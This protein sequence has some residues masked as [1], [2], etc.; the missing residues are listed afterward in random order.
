MY[1]D[2]IYLFKIKLGFYINNFLFVVLVNYTITLLHRNNY[3]TNN[4]DLNFHKN[5]CV[6]NKIICVF[7]LF[8]IFAILKMFV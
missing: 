5:T 3:Y 4:N 7:I 2:P 8:I 1:N 6:I